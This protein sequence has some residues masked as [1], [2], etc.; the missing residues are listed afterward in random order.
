ME[1]SGQFHAPAAFTPRE[2]VPG[3]QLDRSLG[4]SRAGL[5]MVSKWKITKPH[6]ESNSDYPIVHPVASRYTDWAIP[7]FAQVYI[8]T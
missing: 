1:V 4:G 8:W 3:T 2:R 5:D 6:L 7:G